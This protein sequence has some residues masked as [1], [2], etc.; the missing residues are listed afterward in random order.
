MRNWF[1]GLLVT[2]F[3]SALPAQLQAQ[4]PAAETGPDSVL[5]EPARG[6][7]VLRHNA[8]AKAFDGNPHQP[9]DLACGQDVGL[10]QPVQA[11]GRH[12][13]LAT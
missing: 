9:D 7:V 8:H 2:L 4:Q 10:G 11:F 12:A 5:F 1:V 13:V 6:K 3:F